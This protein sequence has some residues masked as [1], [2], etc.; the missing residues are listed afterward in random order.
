M[1]TQFQGVTVWPL[2]RKAVRS[3]QRPA[4]V[5]VA[6]LGQG[7]SR[8]LP[9]P[10]G[11]RLVVDASESAVK[12]GQTCPSEL[13]RL[14]KRG[15]R[16]FSAT[17]LHAKVF[18]VDSKVFVG[19][20][21]VSRR[22]SNALVEAVVMTSDRAVVAGAKRFV[23]DLCM[24]EL[25]PERLSRLGKLYRPP[26]LTGSS[27]L[28][29]RPNGRRVRPALPQVW[30]AQLVAADW[31]EWTDEALERG[32]QAAKDRMNRP[33]RHTIDKFSWGKNPSFRP[34]DIVVQVVKEEDG[35]RMVSP[36]GTVLHIEKWNRRR[37][38]R[39]FVYLEVPVRRRVQLDRLAGRV[40]T[41]G[42]KR[43]MRG[44]KVSPELSERLLEAWGN[45]KGR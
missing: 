32:H 10:P 34:G 39:V 33:R 25:G 35:R 45:G 2:I 19:S 14:Q 23:A 31:P 37:D 26:K 8:L 36:P 42:K 22:S 4:H 5:A 1:T 21:N 18:V 15:V 13:A 27:S 40:G 38:S 17:N 16:V 41:V 44:G 20:A 6:Y 7:A 29:T 9:L 3:S 43:L 24:I 30:I 28:R 11:S 12:S